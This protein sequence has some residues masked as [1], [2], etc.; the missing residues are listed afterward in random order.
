MKKYLV[1]G[2]MSA[3]ALTFVACSSEDDLANVNQNFDGKTVKTQLAVSLPGK[4]AKTRMAEDIVQNEADGSN[5]R[6]ITDLRLYPFTA[7]AELDGY[8]DVQESGYRVA[9]TDAFSGTPFVDGDKME[10]EISAFDHKTT[11]DKWYEVQLPVKTNAMLVYAVA[12]NTEQ[13]FANGYLNASWNAADDP[14]D[15]VNNGDLATNLTFSLQTITD[16]K[17]E[18]EGADVLKALNSLLNVKGK[19]T[20][21]S[22]ATE[23]AWSAITTEQNATY[24]ELYEQYKKMTAGSSASVYALLEDLKESVETQQTAGDFAEKLTDSID[25]AMSMVDGID[26]PGSLDL[27]DGAAKVKF[28][29]D[30]F[31]FVESETTLMGDANMDDDDNV[32]MK[33]GFNT[34]VY[35]AELYYRAN[36]PIVASDEKQQPNVTDG[37]E[38]TSDVIEGLYADASDEVLPTTQSV[39]IVDQIQ[40]AVAN[41]Q[42]FVKFA[43]ATVST[44]EELESG[45]MREIKLDGTLELTGILVGGQKNVDWQFEPTSGEKATEYVVY[46]KE[47]VTTDIDEDTTDPASYTLLLQTAEDEDVNVALEFVN[48]F[49]DENGEP[50][51]F[52]GVNGQIIPFGTKFYLVGKLEASEASAT[53]NCVFKQDF[54]TVAKFTISSVKNAYN[55]VPDL[56][57]PELELGLSVN[58]EWQD[59]AEYEIEF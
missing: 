15:L 43:D 21:A 14:K 11:N 17:L 10:N 2:M 5:F 25:A 59:G 36:S 4:K 30:K 9:A 29:N 49:V 26:F 55:V 34:Y 50:V 40:Y 57:T 18:T 46:D 28:N 31:E 37:D 24:K 16:E 27:P 58:L 52:V 56:R 48:T 39:A 3:M 42:T 1:F 54:R 45:E 35:P 6:T 19:L 41:L 38:W 51:D 20:D 12:E 7:K 13:G 32:E 23:V 33:Y 8:F 44:N 47:L 53:D 22:D